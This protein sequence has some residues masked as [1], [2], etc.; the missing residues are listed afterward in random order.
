MARTFD[1]V[2]ASMK[3]LGYQYGEVALEDV[4]LGWE[5]A[6]RELSSELVM[7]D[8]E[9]YLRTRLHEVEK[10]LVSERKRA[11]VL[12]AQLDYARTLLVLID[13]EDAALD[14]PAG[15]PEYEAYCQA[16]RAMREASER[17]RELGV[18]P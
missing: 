16:N 8:E 11:S 6:Q 5:L 2:W 12:E 18:E 17:L 3:A 14:Q 13:A 1:Q 10:E 15:S 9:M 4:R 7:S